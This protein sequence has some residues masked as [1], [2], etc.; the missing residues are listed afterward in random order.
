M[1]EKIRGK[2]LT[3][4]GGNKIAEGRKVVKKGGKRGNLRPGK[5]G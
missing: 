1:D 4:Q 2:D 5:R 3:S